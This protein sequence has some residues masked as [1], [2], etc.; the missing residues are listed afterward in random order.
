MGEPVL[1]APGLGHV[2]DPGELMAES[3]SG[4]TE[5]GPGDRQGLAAVGAGRCW[6]GT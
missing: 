2:R 5:L 1:H 3:D 6:T 4:V